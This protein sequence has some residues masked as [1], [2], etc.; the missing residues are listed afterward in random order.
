MVTNAIGRIAV[1]NPP[2]VLA[3]VHVDRGDPSVRRLEDREAL[4]AGNVRL[5]VPVPGVLHRRLVARRF[6]DAVDV[7][8]LMRNGVVVAG[9][10]I[11]RPGM[12]VARA[13]RAGPSQVALRT[14]LRRI[15]ENRWCED[16]ADLER[17]EQ[18]ESARPQLRREV[19]EIV[20]D[21]KST[22]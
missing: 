19:D 10:R 21:R 15:I 22:V 2:Q 11:E 1:R 14:S 8:E 6:H 16:R 5:L 17:L 3:G 20:L 12:P 7:R 4:D 13:P 18:I 9:L